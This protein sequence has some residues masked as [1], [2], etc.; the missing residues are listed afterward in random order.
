MRP[1]KRYKLRGHAERT[2]NAAAPPAKHL[3]LIV[4]LTVQQNCVSSACPTFV[5]TSMSMLHPN[6]RADNVYY[7]A[8][9][10]PPHKQRREHNVKTLQQQRHQQQHRKRASRE[11]CT[12]HTRVRTRK[13]AKHPRRWRRGPHVIIA[14]ACSIAHVA[15]S[16][17]A[18]PPHSCCLA[19]CSTP[20]RR[21]LC[22]RSSPPSADTNGL[23]NDFDAQR[24]A[25]AN[26][27]RTHAHKT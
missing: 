17:A 22:C 16:N 7:N 23:I 25:G 8:C 24:M 3:S 6:I 2:V 9:V 12:T 5:H 20:F 15:S 1:Q 14:I 18:P 4:S 27:A 19:M 10:R 26:R 11:I 21:A 13:P